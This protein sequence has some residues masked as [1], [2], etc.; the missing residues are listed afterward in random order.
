LLPAGVGVLALAGGTAGL[1]GA[2]NARARLASGERLP[3][4]TALEVFES[5]KTART[6]GWV[7][8]GVGVLAA[9]TAVG[10]LIAGG[11]SAKVMPV[12]AVTGEGASIGLVGWLP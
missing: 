5:G 6:L 8:L 9:G 3:E 10:L 7:G 1:I 2:E 12:A 4:S 11:S